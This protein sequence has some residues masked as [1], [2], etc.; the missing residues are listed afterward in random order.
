M[1]GAKGILVNVTAGM[2]LSLGEIQEIGE[3]VEEYT[4]DSSTVVI[5]TAIDMEMDGELR[6]TVVATGLNG[7]AEKKVKLIKTPSQENIEI[8]PSYRQ[9]RVNTSAAKAPINTVESYK[10]ESPLTADKDP[11]LSED[12]LDI[13]AFLRNQAD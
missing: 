10:E 4:S 11:M 13:P 8:S 6:V 7:T 1:H 5:G 12:Y 9:S 3:M 2:D